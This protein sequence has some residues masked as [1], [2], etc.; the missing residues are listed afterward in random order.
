MLA[1][2]L[3]SAAGLIFIV[4]YNFRLGL[5]CGL[6]WSDG[7]GFKVGVALGVCR[8]SLCCLVLFVWVSLI[9]CVFCLK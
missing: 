1:W 6:L 3:M 4:A 8:H 5:V 7:F 2:C 9:W